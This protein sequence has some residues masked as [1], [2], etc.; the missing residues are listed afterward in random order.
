MRECAWA[1]YGT[2]ADL[3][4]AQAATP[5]AIFDRVI[6]GEE[7]V[8][9]ALRRCRKGRVYSRSKRIVQFLLVDL[10]DIVSTAILTT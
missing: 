6:E 8:D 10:P 5:F 1:T 9:L 3:S 2:R 4:K 7:I